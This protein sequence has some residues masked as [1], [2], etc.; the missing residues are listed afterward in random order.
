M[1]MVPALFSV[2]LPAPN[3]LKPEV[4]HVAP[5]LLLKV[6]AAAVGMNSVPTISP[7]LLRASVAFDSEITVVVANMPARAISPLAVLLMIAVPVE[8]PLM[9]MAGEFCDLTVPKLPRVAFPPNGPL[10]L[11]PL[12]A[13]NT[14]A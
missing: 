1:S 5:A 12:L 8:L 14:D 11:M 4:Y 2:L 6:T 3:A 10:M 13:P 9:L 7:S